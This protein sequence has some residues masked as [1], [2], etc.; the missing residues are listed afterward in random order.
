MFDGFLREMD[1][2]HRRIDTIHHDQRD[3]GCG[4][5]MF[6][7]VRTDGGAPEKNLRAVVQAMDQVYYSAAFYLKPRS[8]GRRNYF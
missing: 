5:T 2:K 1:T 3:K 8:N 7:I 6:D 4:C